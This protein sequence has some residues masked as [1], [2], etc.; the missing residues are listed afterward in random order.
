MLL[1]LLFQPFAEW[2]QGSICKP[3]EAKDKVPDAVFCPT[4]LCTVNLDAMQ[5]CNLY[6]PPS[7]WNPFTG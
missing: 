1:V 5:L 3:F 2:E 7:Q 6:V 4:F